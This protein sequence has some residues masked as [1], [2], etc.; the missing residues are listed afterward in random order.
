MFRQRSPR[1]ASL[2]TQWGSEREFLRAQGAEDR[3]IEQMKNRMAV[4]TGTIEG[5]YVLDRG[6][7][8][9][10]IAEGFNASLI[11]HADTNRDPKLVVAI[12][13]DQRTAI[14]FVFDVVK[15]HRGLSTSVVKEM[16]VLLTK[17]QPTTT[18]MDQFGQV[19]EVSLLS[20]DWKSAPNNPTRP[21]GSVHLYCP[22][23]RSPRRWT[24]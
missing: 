23:S 3:L 10:L 13:R 22:P 7:T 21:D 18:A 14:D 4:E 19:H 11:S 12:L 15:N 17:H 5:L 20:G 6:V 8:E 1:L 24:D 16:H 9:T 2:A